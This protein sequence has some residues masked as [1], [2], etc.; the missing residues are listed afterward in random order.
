LPAGEIRV[1]VPSPVGHPDEPRA[2]IELA[3]VPAD[4]ER[5]ADDGR[6]RGVDPRERRIAGIG[7]P[8]RACA[9]GHAARAAAGL[10]GAPRTS[11]VRGSRRVTVP[12]MKLVTQ[13]PALP[14][15]MSSGRPPTLIGAPVARA[16]SGPMRETVPS[17]ELVTHRKPPAAAK[18]SGACPTGTAVVR[19]FLIRRMASSPEAA[20]HPAPRGTTGLSG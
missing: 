15:A 14:A 8:A 12:S 3:R 2:D 13:M 17:P 7:H 18:A 1:T 16:V 6:L 19:P 9:D 20:T 10:I 11:P 4:R 5:V